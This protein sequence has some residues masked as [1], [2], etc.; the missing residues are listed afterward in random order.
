VSNPEQGQPGPYGVPPQS[1]QQ[2]YGA[3]RQQPSYGAQPQ[4]PQQPQ[5]YGAPPQQQYGAP[6]QPGGP[7]QQ[8]GPPQGYS[9]YAPRPR[10]TPDPSKPISPGV[11]AAGFRAAAI[12]IGLVAAVLL[13]SSLLSF[14][15]NLSYQGATEADSSGY[16]PLKAF[17]D[18][19]LFS[20]FPFYAGAFAAFAFLTPIVRK[21]ALPVVLLRAVLAGAGGTIIL[22]V[23]GV[24]TG[25]TKAVQQNDPTWILTDIVT[26]PIA[27][28][29]QDTAMLAAAAVATWLW[30]G[31][32]GARRRMPVA[33]PG[34]PG[35]V[36]PA[37]AVPPA[38]VPQNRPQPYGAPVWGQPGAQPGSAQ[39]PAPAS[40]PWS[41]GAQP[42]APQ[43]QPGAWPG[44]QAPGQQAPGQPPQGGDGPAGR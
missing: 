13:V 23:V 2:P 36:P 14:L 43:P 30:L 28:G 41:G 3:P 7:Q 25:F 12:A 37:D 27:Q 31:R 4:Q 40:Q 32:P 38:T 34:M 44:Q 33:T 20:P 21:S 11:S 22:M 5:P 19:W 1:Q 15:G 42:S 8:Y 18:N 26:D 9:G 17:F 6:Q 10:R 24:F 39:P 29:I 35:T 16:V